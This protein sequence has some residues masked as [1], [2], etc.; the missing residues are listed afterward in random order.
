MAS[1][2]P[3]PT[4][5]FHLSDIHFGLEDSQALDWVKQEIA[6]RRPAAVAITG[7]L[8]KGGPLPDRPSRV[9]R[10]SVR[11]LALRELEA[12]AGLGAAVLLALDDAAVAGQEAGGLDRA[13]Q[14][15]LDTWSAPGRCRA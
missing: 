7:D 13:A 15:R 14:R 5:L 4:T 8:K 12:L 11:G 6:E 3:T 1:D 9:V 2:A 10:K